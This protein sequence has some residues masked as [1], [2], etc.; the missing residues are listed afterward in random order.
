[1]I[2]SHEVENEPVRG[3]MMRKAECAQGKTL[4]LPEL[5][6]RARLCRVTTHLTY[7]MFCH[8]ETLFTI[9]PLV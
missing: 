4:A 3:L 6:R 8:P 2:T 1:M 7:S 5:V 9:F